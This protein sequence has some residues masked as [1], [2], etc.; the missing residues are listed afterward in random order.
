MQEAPFV[1]K[2]SEQLAEKGFKFQLENYTLNAK[3]EMVLTRWD[4]MQGTAQELLANVLAG[5]R[6]SCVDAEDFRHVGDRH[7]CRF[8]VSPARTAA[9]MGNNYFRLSGVIE[10][11]PA[12]YV[13]ALL[14]VVEVGNVDPTLRFYRALH[15]FDDGKTRICH[16]VAQ[17]GPR[18]VFSDRDDCAL[19]SYHVDPDGT[20][21]Q[22]STSAP[23]HV[24]TLGIK[25][26]TMWWAYRLEPFKAANGQ[27]H[28]RFTLVTQTEL[29]GWM[30]R[31]FARAPGE[32]T[33][34]RALGGAA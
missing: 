5:A 18:P 15:D 32:L 3:G 23:S 17:T 25:L 27:T 24:G 26:W 14:S 11:P 22:M 4:G 29:N 7:G 30:V 19:T 16:L 13:A 20:W 6:R 21:W 2:G 34:E 12:L 10:I 1:G 33:L 31:V 28:T 8:E 9:G